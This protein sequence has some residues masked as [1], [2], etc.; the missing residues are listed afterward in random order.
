MLDS[1]PGLVAI[2]A[3]PGTCIVTDTRVLHCGGKRTASGTRYA[4]RC[5]YN[6][7]YIRALHEHSQA[8]LHV[9]NDVYQV[10]SD[11]LKHMMGISMNNSDPVKEMKA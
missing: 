7:H 4:M 6:R 5:H 1:E 11:R 2:C 8:N 3:P 9:P 10:L